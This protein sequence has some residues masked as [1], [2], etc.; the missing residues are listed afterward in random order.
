VK[1]IETN[2]NLPAM[3]NSASD[4]AAGSLS[5]LFDFQGDQT[6]RLVLDPTTGEVGGSGYG[7]TR[8]S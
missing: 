8:R 7:D 6:P 5:S 1:F 3:G 2:W 4:Q